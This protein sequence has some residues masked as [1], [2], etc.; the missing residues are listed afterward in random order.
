M[1]LSHQI[2]SGNRV[3]LPW[4][5]VLLGFSPARG[6]RWPRAP[7]PDL[8]LLLHLERLATLNHFRVAS[9][10]RVRLGTSS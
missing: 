4:M 9:L 1:N 7:D 3:S 8:R 10:A 5:N 2:L 6:A